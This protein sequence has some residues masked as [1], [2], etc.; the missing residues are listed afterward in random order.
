MKK[1]SLGTF[2]SEAIAALE[3]SSPSLSEG[4]MCGAKVTSTVH[5]VLVYPK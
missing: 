3:L 2:G 4:V 1:A 5:P